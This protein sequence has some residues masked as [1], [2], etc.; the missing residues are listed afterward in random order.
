MPTHTETWQCYDLEW[1]YIYKGCSS[2]NGKTNAEIMTTSANS[3]ELSC[4]YCQRTLCWMCDCACKWTSESHMLNTFISSR[5]TP[6]PPSLPIPI[7]KQIGQP[8]PW[9]PSLMGHDWFP[10][11]L[12][13]KTPSSSEWNRHFLYCPNNCQHFTWTMISPLPN[14]QLLFASLQGLDLTLYC[15]QNTMYIPQ[16]ISEILSKWKR[17]KTLAMVVN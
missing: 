10:I 13:S 1:M 2:T 4:H 16:L 14:T 3:F 11:K 6:P 15:F 5:R 12:K 9:V 8:V 7:F 17:W